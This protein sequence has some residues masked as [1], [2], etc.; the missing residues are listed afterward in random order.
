MSNAEILPAPDIKTPTSGEMS[1]W[2]REKRAF[3]ALHSSLLSKHRGLY[4]A[5]HE[6][7]VVGSGLDQLGVAR[8]AYRRYGYV[9]IYVGLVTDNPL[10]PVRV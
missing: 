1:K 5:I 2:E 7:Q 3:R 4:V 9:P 8:E 6:E 10:P